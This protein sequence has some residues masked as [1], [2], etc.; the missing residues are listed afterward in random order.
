MTSVSVVSDDD[1]EPMKRKYKEEYIKYSMENKQA[2]VMQPRFKFY[3][4]DDTGD[5]VQELLSIH[6][7]QQILLARTS[8]VSK[9]QGREG[10]KGRRIDRIA[11]DLYMPLFSR[12][13]I[14]SLYGGIERFLICKKTCIQQLNSIN[15]D[16]S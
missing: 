7:I 4:Y 14:R 5:L 6:D 15:I 3:L 11:E 16:L 13:L 10:E 2:T 9:Q 12:T 8:K 1:P